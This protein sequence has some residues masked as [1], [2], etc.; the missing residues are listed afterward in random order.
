MQRTAGAVA[1]AS[2]FGVLNRQAA[3]AATIVNGVSPPIRKFILPLRGLGPGGIPVATPDQLTYPGVDFYRLG[4]VEH[5]ELLHPDLPG[6]TR[7]WG[8][9]D[10]SAGGD[11]RKVHLGAVVVAN[12]G[13]PSRLQINNELGT[14]PHL[15][16]V[17]LSLPGA[18][19]GPR[20]IATHLHGGFVPWASDGGPFHTVAPDGTLGASMVN[21]LPDTAGTLTHDLWYPNQQTPRLMW[22]HDHSMGITRLNAYAGIASA[23]LLTGPDEAAL[24][25]PGGALEGIG[26]GIP[27]VFQDK[28]FKVVA[29]QWGGP[30]DLDYPSV[31]PQNIRGLPFPSCVPEFFGDTMLCNGA[32]YPAVNVEPKR[33]RFRILNA[34]QAGFLNLSIFYAKNN[35]ATSANTAA[36]GPGWLQIGTEGGFLPA[37]VAIAPQKIAFSTTGQP[38]KYSLLL[39][40]AERADVIVDFSAV[41]VGSKLIIYNDAPQPFPGGVAPVAP[42]VKGMGP[43]TTN[44]VQFTVVPLTSPDVSAGR[45]I[46]LPNIDV[47]P[48]SGLTPQGKTLN[49]IADVYGRLIQML[50]TATPVAPGV[51]ARAY[52]DPATEVVAAGALQVWDIYNLTMDT[53][54]MHFHLVNVQVLGRAPFNAKKAIFAP[55]APF[56]LPD[57]NELGYKETVRMNPGTV[58]RVAMRFDLPTLPATIAGHPVVL[59][60]SPRTGGNEYVWHC[61]IL[62]HEEHDMM[63]PLIVV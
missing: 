55:T 10:R 60:N 12:Q 38:L 58:T 15:L 24:L 45:P 16:P 1:G 31:Y 23:Y 40:P 11:N 49:E 46:T 51:F 35:D 9:Y 28:V 21:W 62:E 56:V 14:G 47:L 6:P 37:P 53:H 33:Y 25:A 39:A 20:R 48:V 57:A 13:R 59:P 63:R 36:P 42:L 22:Y 41:P 2:I 27:L 26:L 34:N 44:L 18:A 29:D 7:L 43:D 52:T 61:H 54:P 19:D 4:V 5:A 30:G 50:G 17:D 3:S 8:Y 32:P